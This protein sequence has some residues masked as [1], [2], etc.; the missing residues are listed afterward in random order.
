MEHAI[1]FEVVGLQSV[2]RQNELILTCQA[3]KLR[4]YFDLNL[5]NPFGQKCFVAVGTVTTVTRP[6]AVAVD[7]E[8]LASVKWLEQAKFALKSKLFANLG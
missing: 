4:I 1:G 3:V 7:A 8:Q 6:I 5:T 2:K